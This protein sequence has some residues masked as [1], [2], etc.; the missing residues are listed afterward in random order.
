MTQLDSLYEDIVGLYRG[1]HRLEMSGTYSDAYEIIDQDYSPLT[2]CDEFSTRREVLNALTGLRQRLGEYADANQLVHDNL[3]ASETYLRTVL[4]ERFSMQHYVS[5]LYLYDPALI[6]GPVLDAAAAEV[7]ELCG[8]FDLQYRP[9]DKDAYL[10]RFR[11]ESGEEV[12]SLARASQDSWLKRLYTY[13]DPPDDLKIN[14]EIVDRD[15]PWSFFL[16][17]KAD[18]STF[19]INTHPRHTFTRGQCKYIASHEIAG[20]AVQN[21]LWARAVDHERLPSALQIRTTH[22]PLAALAEGIAQALP[23]FLCSKSELDPEMMLAKRLR[24]LRDMV[25]ANAQLMLEDGASVTASWEYCA[26]RL[27]FLEPFEIERDLA[28]RSLRPAERAYQHCYAPSFLAYL[29]VA[30]RLH[31]DEVGDFL[32]SQYQRIPSVRDFW[33]RNQG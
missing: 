25:L 22:H 28:D 21:P 29:H 16:S 20:H 12:A 1:W 11:V 7:R 4:G 32:R 27:F 18:S 9:E 14:V 26:N 15:E 17:S 23:Y 30:E 13:I 8:H 10:A 31:R 24:E 19:A 5:S 33:R 3:N 6:P 2:R